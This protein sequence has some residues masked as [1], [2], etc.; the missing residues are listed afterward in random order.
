MPTAAKILI[1][2]DDLE[3]RQLLGEQLRDLGHESIY[4]A[5]GIQALS[6]VRRE[7]PDLMLLDLLLPA[8]DGF[9]VLERLRNI[10]EIAYIPVIVF[11]GSRSPAAE[12]RALMLGAREY[13]RKSF[14]GHALTEAIARVLEHGGAAAPVQPVDPPAQGGPAT[15]PK[16]ALRQMPAWRFSG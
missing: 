14:S 16:D 11:S 8:G 3:I 12:E 2:D 10:P 5:D 9:C 7:R 1:V 4:A 6:L 13:V 15:A